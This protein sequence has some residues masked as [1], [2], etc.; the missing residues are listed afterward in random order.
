MK[1]N[2]IIVDDEPASRDLLKRYIADTDILN[3]VAECKNAIE[4][5]EVLKNESIH[6]MFLDINMPKVTGI[7]LLKSL[8]I[9]PKVIF[10]TAYAEYAID[11][12]ELDAVD[13]LLKPFPFERFLKAVNKYLDI[14]EKETPVENRTILLK[15]EKKLYRIP[16][17][18]IDFIEA[19]GDYVKVVFREQ[20]ITVHS[21]FQDLLEQIS[22]PSFIRI[23]RSFA[24]SINNFEYIDGNQIIV[25]GNTLPIGKAFR[26]G[27][28]DKIEI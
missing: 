27:L 12:F 23:H 15:S 10:S 17:L 11:G 21:T 2:C 24:I 7:Q 18:D 13:Y 3:L 4:A 26:K 8:T 9:P 19:I 5:N 1:V 14:A 16:I 6:L 22:Y 20:T 28:M 25:K